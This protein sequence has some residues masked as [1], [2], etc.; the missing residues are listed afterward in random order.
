MFVSGHKTDDDDDDDD[1]DDLMGVSNARVY[2][3]ILIFRPVSHFV[4][5]MIQDRPIVTMEGE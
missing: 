3:K 1:D 5:Q 4:C 2:E